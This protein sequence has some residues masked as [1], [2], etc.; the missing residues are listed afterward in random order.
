MTESSLP[1]FP[2]RLRAIPVPSI[3]WVSPYLHP[4]GVSL[5]PPQRYPKEQAQ[6]L[7]KG[8]SLKNSQP[9]GMSEQRLQNSLPEDL[10]VHYFRVTGVCRMCCP[11]PLFAPL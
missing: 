5:F 3:S 11:L 4:L 6:I 8:Q 7:M 10:G 1:L 9:E 2:F